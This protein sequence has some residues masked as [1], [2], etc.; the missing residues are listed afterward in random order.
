MCVTFT[1]SLDKMSGSSGYYAL[2]EFMS[3]RRDTQ[4]FRRFSGLN[5]E[6][7]LHMQAELLGLE[8]TL[9]EVRRDPDHNR[10]NT[11]WL[12]VPQSSGTSAVAGIFERARVLLDQ[13]RKSACYKQ[14][15]AK[16]SR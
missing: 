2:A 9:E 3:S 7:L 4:F 15:L 14:P 1:G 10:F 13:Y 5:I 6:S 11:S 16:D 8:L 12:G